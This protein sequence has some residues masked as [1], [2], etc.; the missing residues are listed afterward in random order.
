LLLP[1]GYDGQGPEHSSAHI[2]RFLTLCADDNLQIVNATTAAQFFHVLRRQTRRD[3]RRPLVIF[4]PK[5]LLRAR[6]AR[7]PVADLNVGSFEEVLDDPAAPPV[8]DVRRILLT[9]GK[10]AYDAMTRR[11][12]TSAP[13][14]VLRVEQLYPWP[15]DELASHIARYEH[16]REVVW[17]QEEPE[18]IGPWP[19]LSGRVQRLLRPDCKFRVASRPESDSPATGSLTVHRQEQRDLMEDAFAGL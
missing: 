3:V 18:N 1:H 7:S 5:S 10:V 8:D 14:A 9:S 17:L 4:T 15:G 2:E 12:S 11:D 16:A 19:F 13:V 6:V